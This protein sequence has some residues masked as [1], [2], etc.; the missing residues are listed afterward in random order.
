MDGDLPF[1][2]RVQP[3]RFTVDETRQEA[4]L[5]VELQLQMF[6]KTH[7]TANRRNRH[8]P[9]HHLGLQFYL[10]SPATHSVQMQL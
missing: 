2:L 7:T 9:S 6:C 10:H 4:I 5:L 8:L 3:F 1:D